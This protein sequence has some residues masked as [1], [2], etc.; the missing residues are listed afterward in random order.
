V[1]RAA[2]KRDSGSSELRDWTDKLTQAEREK[3]LVFTG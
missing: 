2:K 3:D 1:K